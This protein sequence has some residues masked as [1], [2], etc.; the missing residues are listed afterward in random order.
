MVQGPEEAAPEMRLPG[1]AS[2][3][4]CTHLGVLESIEALAAPRCRPEGRSGG[5]A[6]PMPSTAQRR[7]YF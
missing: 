6:A 3:R 2:V 7:L 4:C 5:G 1:N